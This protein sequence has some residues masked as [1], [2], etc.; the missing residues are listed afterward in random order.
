MG[1]IASVPPLNSGGGSYGPHG[2]HGPPGPV[3]GGPAPVFDRA[4]AILP[5]GASDS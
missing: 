3:A 4:D 2:P 5:R 1:R